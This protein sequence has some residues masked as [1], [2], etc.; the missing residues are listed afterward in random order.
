[1]AW[2]LGAVLNLTGSLT[3][4]SGVN[5]VRK[6]TRHK[7]YNLSWKP[8]W[9]GGVSLWVLGN[10][11]I[12]MSFGL[13]P[14]LLLAPL[15][16]AQFV[17]NVLQAWMVLGM[18][19]DLSTWKA[20]C[21]LIL[22]ISLAAA[23]APK[24]EQRHSSAYLQ[25][26]YLSIEYMLYLVV[27]AVV[28]G[29][30]QVLYSSTQTTGQRKLVSYGAVSAGLGSQSMVQ[31]KVLSMLLQAGWR[32]E[33]VS[34][35]LVIVAGV[36]FAGTYAFWLL[37][38]KRG[39]QHLDG[40]TLIPI[41]QA[42]WLPL[43]ALSCG[44]FFEE[45]K[46]LSIFA[47]PVYCLGLLAV[48]L[49]IY[50]IVP[51]PALTLEAPN[52]EEDLAKLHNANRRRAH[53]RMQKVSTF[54]G[55]GLTDLFALPPQ[56]TDTGSNGVVMNTHTSLE[57]AHRG[58]LPGPLGHRSTVQMP[59]S[60]AN[61][62]TMNVTASW[63]ARALPSPSIMEDEENVGEPHQLLRRWSRELMHRISH[64]ER[65]ADCNPIMEVEM[66]NIGEEAAEDSDQPVS[67]S[68]PSPR[69]YADAP[70]AAAA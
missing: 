67:M 7:E 22:S 40:A 10:S 5:F 26:R 55:P 35:L 47:L 59:R 23:M 68:E 1:M 17:T 51:D 60:H 3:V 6:A 53:Q 57:M 18:K 64:Q 28:V 39:L 46:H 34:F 33:T 19:V 52:G 36:F 30:L 70:G 41:M 15:C 27:L 14:Q 63:Q 58:T 50:L 37:R 69:S 11:L 44:V 61:R 32:G 25:Q 31:L 56:K 54:V 16:A 2:G 45:F 8:L 20:L 29:M 42:F 21:V 9:Y 48:L 4:S 62:G 66:A 65:G 38:A 24:H 12:A 13:A 49:G 43:H